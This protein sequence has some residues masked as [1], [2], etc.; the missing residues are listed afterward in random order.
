MGK[1]KNKNKKGGH[2][3]GKG[4]S[5]SAKKVQHRPQEKLD[6]ASRQQKN[7]AQEEIIRREMASTGVANSSS[8][9]DSNASS[10]NKSSKPL[11]ALQQK[12]QKKLEGARFRV[13]NERLYT[14]TGDS[15]FE[16]FQKDP[17]L[18]TIYHQGFREQAAQWPYNPLDAII[19]SIKKK[20][21]GKVVAD[22]GCGDARL[23]LSV[24]NKV[25]SFDLVSQNS[26]VVACDMAHLPL[27]DASVDIAVFCLALMGSNIPDFIKEAHRVLRPSGLIK[28]AE[29]RSRFEEE[30]GNGVKNFSRFLK[31]AGFDIVPHTAANE[32][33]MFFEME[34]TKSDREPFFG[35]E[36]AVKACIYK[37][38]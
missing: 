3:Q 30:G 13:I 31:R 29:V 7:K 37:R 34:L 14:T 17:S 38:R 11:S 26:R 9:S 20:H 27:P 8:S 1:N 15:A 19:D 28:I 12:F 16:E 21:R 33:K 18:F 6:I 10:N 32:N 22:I 5:G 36:M 35:E 4:D 24:P 23:S 25:H 2:K